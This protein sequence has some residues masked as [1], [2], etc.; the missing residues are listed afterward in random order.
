MSRYATQGGWR[1]PPG[2][3]APARVVNRPDRSGHARERVTEKLWR[4]TERH[5][6]ALEEQPLDI[7]QRSLQPLARIT[8]VL[9]EIEKHVRPAYPEHDP[10]GEPEQPRRSIHELRDELDGQLNRIIR[11][12]EEFEERWGRTFENGAGI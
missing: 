6:A 11:E 12:E 4:L 9:G 1:R 3:A 7:A 10:Y 8:R 2:A 5:A